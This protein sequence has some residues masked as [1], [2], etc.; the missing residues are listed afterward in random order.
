MKRIRSIGG[1]AA[2]GPGADFYYLMLMTMLKG[3]P[4]RHRYCP[5]NWFPW[6]VPP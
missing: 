2:A 5:T 6:T 3:P 4:P 1:A